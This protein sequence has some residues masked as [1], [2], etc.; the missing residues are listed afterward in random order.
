MIIE[1]VMIGVLGALHILSLSF[2][3]K[4]VK[5]RSKEE[6]NIEEYLIS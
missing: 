6:L 1:F 4:K 3:L 2:S 5:N